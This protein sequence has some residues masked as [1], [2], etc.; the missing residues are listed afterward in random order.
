MRACRP[1]RAH[2][3]CRTA[4]IFHFEFN[5][6]KM[7]GFRGIWTFRTQHWPHIVIFFVSTHKKMHSRGHAI[8]SLSPPCI[9]ISFGFVIT[10]H[11]LLQNR[12]VIKK[13]RQNVFFIQLLLKQYGQRN[14]SKVFGRKRV[15]R[16]QATSTV[17]TVHR[18]WTWIP[19]LQIAGHERYF[20]SIHILRLFC[21]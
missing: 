10:T 4:I 2:C 21:I 14:I 8:F 3:P 7:H 20:A 5:Y 11:W 9:F 16:N 12:F 6:F 13:G 17:H 19:L 15:E 1:V 18:N